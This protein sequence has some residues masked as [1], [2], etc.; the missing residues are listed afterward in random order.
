MKTMKIKSYI[1]ILISTFIVLSGI[2]ITTALGLWTT[3]STKIP[4][5]LD[6]SQSSQQ[7][8]SDSQ[9]SAAD[10]A[11]QSLPEYDPSGIKGSYTFGEISNL[12]KIPLADLSAAFLVKEG[13]AKDFKCKDLST[14][15]SEA[16]NEIGTASVRMFVSFFYGIDYE[17]T[18]SVYL[19][20]QAFDILKANSKITAK[21]ISY[22]E[23]HTINFSP[24]S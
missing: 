14:I 9:S 24:P 10:S 3:K 21:Q 6:I 20:K 8:L 19:T 17:S 16:D 15:F 12:Y 1:A 2:A 11:G 22:L 5:K 18:E 13:Q 23:T 7:L 4:K